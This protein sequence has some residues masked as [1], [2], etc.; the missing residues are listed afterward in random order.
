M[1]MLIAGVLLWSALH[2][3]P[4]IGRGPRQSA[5]DTLGEGGYKG[6]FSLLMLAA[7]ALMV[8]GWR[9]AL[10]QSIYIPSQEMRLA[11]LVLVVIGFIFMAAANRPSRF[12]RL[13][14]HPQ[15]FGV[16]LWAVAH[17]LA[18]GD[19][20]SLVLFGGLGAWCILMMPLINRRD[21]PW[22][23]PEAPSWLREVVGVLIALVAVA[24]VTAIHPWIAGMPAVAW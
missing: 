19:S 12:G 13:V 6:I 7:I 14:R 5:I 9:S 1:L 10:P 17:L 11:G 8:F 18:N 2:L 4:V 22:T 16:L 20:R 23:K 15:L 24:V 3:V 21:G